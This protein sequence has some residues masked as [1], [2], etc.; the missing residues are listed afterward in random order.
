M[1]LMIIRR[2]WNESFISILPLESMD[3]TGARFISLSIRA[4]GP[5]IIQIR[6]PS[7]FN[8]R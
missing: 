4:S 2:L 5:I 8:N 1:V 3:A 7:I 6:S